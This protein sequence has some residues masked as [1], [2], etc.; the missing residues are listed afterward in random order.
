MN[1]Q[2]K[3]TPQQFKNTTSDRTESLVAYLIR[4]QKSFAILVS[5]TL[6]VMVGV[7]LWHRYQDQQDRAAQSDMYQA[8]YKFEAGSFEKALTGDESHAGFLD[9]LQDYR[10]TKAANLAHLYVGIIY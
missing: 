1:R 10:F 5:L 3:S 6:A 8:T 9:I 7:L 4:R 2:N